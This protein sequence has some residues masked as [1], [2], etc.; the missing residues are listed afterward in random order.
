M[1]KNIIALL[2]L[3]K[4]NSILFAQQKK[5]YFGYTVN[6]YEFV[7]TVQMVEIICGVSDISVFQF[8]LRAYPWIINDPNPPVYVFRNQ[9]GE[10]LKAYSLCG[11]HISDFDILPP[12]IV[13]PKILKKHIYSRYS[14]IEN[15]NEDSL[16]TSGPFTLGSKYANADLTNA[17]YGVV[18]NLGNV[19]VSPQYDFLGIATK[20][21]ILMARL[22]NKHGILDED[23]KVIQR[24]IYDE[25]ECQS[26]DGGM[27]L[28]TSNGKAFY[29][30]NKGELISKHGYDFGEM[31]WSRRARVSYNGKFGYIDSTGAEVVPLIYKNAEPFYYNVAVVGNGKKY[32]MINNLG[33]IIEPLEYDRIQDIYDEKE[34]VTI[35]YTGFKNGEAFYFDREGKRVAKLKDVK[36]KKQ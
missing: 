12:S 13:N 1:K 27:F 32:G 35:G 8:Q 25:L 6:Y 2:I 19:I 10:V 5:E 33:G 16:K 17:K 31:F 22:K 18:D 11:L 30:N 15:C 24:I 29:A 21:N 14:I 4:C 34:M 26:Y 3:L 36:F 9:K 7:D 28:L 23:G 20:E